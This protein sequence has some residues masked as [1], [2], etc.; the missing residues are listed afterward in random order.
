MSLAISFLNYGILGHV[1]ENATGDVACDSYHKYKEDVA[2]L[3]DLGVKLYRFSVSWPRIMPDGT[4]F[5][6]NQAG[7]DYYINLVQVSD[8]PKKSI[9]F[10]VIQF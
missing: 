6:I 4:P 7:L 9:L 10:R 5:Y 1:Q 2:I 8:I 3:K